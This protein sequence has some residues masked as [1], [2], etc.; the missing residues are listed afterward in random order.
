[1][2][3]K[4]RTAPK[5]V[6]STNLT[7]TDGTP[8]TD[9]TFITNL[10]HSNTATEP[11]A[12][13]GLPLPDPER[14]EEAAEAE[15]ITADEQ[16]TSVSETGDG[17]KRKR[18]AD[19][20]RKILRPHELIFDEEFRAR[21]KVCEKTIAEYKDKYKDHVDEVVKMLAKDP[22]K[23]KSIKPPLGAIHVWQKEKV[24]ED[25][26]DETK[27]KGGK[28]V[29]VRYEFYVTSGWHRAQAALEAGV[30]Y[31]QCIVHSNRNVAVQQAL[32]TNRH[33]KQLSKLDKKRSIELALAQDPDLSNQAL[34]DHL[35]C[36]KRSVELIVKEFNLRNEGD[37]KP[38]KQ[39]APKEKAPEAILLDQVKT[40]LEPTLKSKSTH[41][42]RFSACVKVL[43][44]LAANKV[45]ENDEECLKTLE[46]VQKLL[47]A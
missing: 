36:S 41:Q 8:A 32:E 26:G 31:L 24:S 14:R 3:K 5:S 47:L 40:I 13:D 15:P 20:V 42:E 1:M 38:K 34:A 27:A 22:G 10:E 12:A 18:D 19:T 4:N 46:N 39:R 43:E 23:V 21:D 44:L 7:T 25:G 35:G 33:G 28:K 9:V 11:A 45:V 17:K 29:K 37:G 16:T 30:P 2:E 6:S